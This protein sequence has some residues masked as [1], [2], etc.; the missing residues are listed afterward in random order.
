MQQIIEDN[1]LRVYHYI[2]KITLSNIQ[3]GVFF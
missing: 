3:K 2:K 1:N